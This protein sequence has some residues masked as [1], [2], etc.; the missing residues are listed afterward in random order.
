[1]DINLF[2]TCSEK[3]SIFSITNCRSRSSQ[4]FH[5]IFFKYSTLL[6]LKSEIECCLSTKRKC[7]SIWSFI[8][9]YFFSIFEGKWEKIYLVGKSLI[10]LHRSDIRIHEN[11]PNAVFFECLDRLRTGII[12]FS[13]LANL[14]PTR[15][16]KKN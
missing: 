11:Y 15:T 12:K 3:R 5:R 9:N 4:N 2:Q 6:K 8:S 13:R 16:E 7:D 14:E 10:S 1:M